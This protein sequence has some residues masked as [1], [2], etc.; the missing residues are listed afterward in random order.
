[1]TETPIARF[2][3]WFRQARKA[4]VILPEAMVLATADRSGRPSARFMLLK[5]A[6][7]NG[8]VFYTNV[9][10]RKGKELRDNPRAEMVF[11]WDPIGR[12]VR[13]EGRIEPVPTPEVDA[14]WGTRPRGSQLAALAST[15]SAE[16]QSRAALTRRQEE[17]RRRYR[18][19]KIP[20]PAYWQGFRLVPESIEFWV[21]RIHRLH[22]R[23]RFT[24]TKAGWRGA[25]LQ[26]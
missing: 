1:M 10:S 16:I 3:R 26:P 23:E 20:R 7:E 5:D 14:Y 22:E 13:V 24:R 21:R 12:Q 9:K 18:G 11:Y 4:G 17:L 19:K 25:V 15:Q 6:A 2:H 8:F